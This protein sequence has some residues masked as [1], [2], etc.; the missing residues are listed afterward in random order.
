MPLT[1]AIVRLN[2]NVI[3][4]MMRTHTHSAC[5]KKV[6]DISS[7]SMNI[8]LLTHVGPTRRASRSRKI[9]LETVCSR[10]WGLNVV[11]NL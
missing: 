3:G 6:G 2:L 10:P 9:K 5:A 1:V 7:E 11:T 8:D 4:R